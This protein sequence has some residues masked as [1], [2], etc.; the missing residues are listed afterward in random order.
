MV[1]SSWFSRHV[2]GSWHLLF[3]SFSYPRGFANGTRTALGEKNVTLLCRQESKP[4]NNTLA[5]L[6]IGLQTQGSSCQPVDFIPRE[7][8]TSTMWAPSNQISNHKSPHGSLR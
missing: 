7:N 1:S 4:T 8:T 3:G 2:H 5:M 6:S